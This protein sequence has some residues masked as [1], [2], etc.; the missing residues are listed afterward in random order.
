MARTLGRGS[1]YSE[2]NVHRR[3]VPLMFSLLL[4]SEGAMGQA[5]SIDL[6]ND[7]TICQGQTVTLTAPAGYPNYLWSTGASSQSIVVG[8]AGTFWGEA[9]YTSAQ[10]FPNSDFSAGATGF[11]TQ[12]NHSTVLV[13]EGNYWVGTNA[14]TYHPNFFGTGTGNFMMV[15]SGWPSAL[16]NVYCQDVVVCPQQTY[17]LRY[18]ARTLTNDIPAR[19]QWWVNGSPVGPEV[20]MPAFNAGWQTITQT[21]TSGV[22]VTN[23]NACLRVMSGDGIGNDFGIDDVTMQGTMRL[24][25]EVIVNVTPL[26]VF[27]LGPNATL[28]AGQNLVLDAAVPGGSYVWQDG[29]TDPGYVV[30]GPGTYSVT[31]T[32]NGCPATDAITVNYNALPVVNLGPDRTL[33]VGETTVLNATL[34]GATYVWQDGSTNGTYTVTGPGTYSVQVT[35]NNCPATDAVDIVYTPLPTVDLGADVDVCSGDVVLLDAT[36]TNGSY[37]WQDGSTGATFSPTT[38]GTYDVTV[39]VD[40][41]DATDAVNVNFRPLPLADLGPDQ[42]VCPGTV[43]TLD[44]TTAGASY[45]WQDGSTAPTLAATSPGTYDVEVT[46]NGCSANDSFTLSHFVLQTV[47]LGPDITICQGQAAT[48]GALVAG[49]GYTWSTGDGTATIGVS[50]AGTYWV[51]VAL[52][53]C[54]VRDSVNVVVTPLPVIELGPDAMICPGTTVTLDATTAE[55]TYTW[56]TG[57]H[58]ATLDVAAGIYDVTVT[59][60]NCTSTDNITITEWPAATV[61]LGPDVTLCPGTQ[62]ILDAA[63]PGASHVWQDGSTNST[64]TVT[65]GGTYD[66]ELTD[67]NGCTAN[68]AIT[69]TYASP[70]PIDLGADTTLCQGEALTLDATTPGASYVWNTGATT[71]TITVSSGGNYSVIVTQGSCTVSDAIVVSISQLPSVSLGPDVLLCPT[72]TLILDATGPGFTYAWS[73]GAITPTITVTTGGTYTVTVTNTANCTANDAVVVTYATPGSIDLGPD[74]VRCQGETVVLDASLPGAT[75]VWSTGASTPTITVNSTGTFSVTV[76]QGT[77]SVTDAVD[78][79]VNPMPQ[80]DLGNDVTLCAGEDI[81]LD[82]TWP[83]ASYAWSSGASTPTITV[84]STGTFSVDVDL[85]GCIASDAIDVNVLSATSVDVGP[86]QVICEGEQVI[87]DATTPGSSYVWSNGATTP[88]ITVT[89]SGTYSVTVS[90]GLC[91]V[92]DAVDVTVNPMPQVDLGN[93]VTLCAGED[94]LLDATWPGAS[95]A[96]SSGASTPT[97]TVNS[98]GTFSVDVDLNGCIASDA[99]DVNV[100]SATSVD[101]GPDQVICEGEQVILD[102]TTPGSSYVWSTGATT[103]TITVTTSGIYSVTVS[104]GLCSVTDAVDVT[105]NPMPQVDLGNDVTLCAGEDILLDATWPGASYAWSSGASTPTITVN[106]TGTFSVDVD[107]NGCIASDAIDVSVLSATSVD[108]GPDQVICEGEQVILDA[109]TPGSSYVW[110]TGATTPTITVTSSGTYS[111]TVSTGLCS[112]TD[113]VDVTM[114]PMPQVDLGADQVFCA[115]ETTT[116]LDATWPGANYVWSTGATTPTIEVDINGPYNV[117]VEL[118][119]CVATDMLTVTFGS[120]NYSLGADTTLCPGQTLLLGSDLPAGTAVWNGT[121]GS[122]TITVEQAGTYRLSFTT[123]S[124]CE[125]RDTIEVNYVGIDQV[126]LGADQ[127]LCEGEVLQ[128]DATTAGATYVWDDGSTGAVR[129]VSYSGEY[130]VEVHVGQCT[131]TDA[132]NVVFNP[133]P[134][135]NLGAD[136]PLCPTTTTTFDATTVDASYLWQDGSTEPTYTASHAGTVSVTVSVSGCSSSDAVEVTQLEGPSLLLGSDTTICSGADLLLLVNEA[137]TSYAWDD[138]SDTEERVVATE[139]YYWV[140]ATRNTCTVRDSIYV[141]VFSTSDLDLGSDITICAGGSTTL[142]A[143]YPGALYQWNTG[144]TSPTISVN[145]AG[146]YN[147]TIAVSGCSAEDDIT[148][149]VFALQPPQ[150]GA[151]RT[152]CEGESTE[153]S[154]LPTNAHILWSTGA[155]NNSI[156]V[157][158]AGTYTVTLD[159]LG[160]TASDI[161]RVSTRPM[162]TRIDLGPDRE[163]C[164]G[165]MDLLQAPFIAGASYTWT[166]GSTGAMLSIDAPGTYGVHATGE[167]IDARATIIVSPADCGTYIFVPNTFTPNG[168]GDNDLFLPSIAGPLD[169]YQLDIFDRWGERIHTTDDRSAGWDGQYNG[170]A[171]Q[172]GV[173]VWTLHYRVLGP[174]GVK[175]ERLVGHVTLLR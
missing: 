117:E 17:T 75:Y 22:G 106:S 55:A 48:I 171:A 154:I 7:H 81:L 133:L 153:L 132:I 43:V 141:N 161:I 105:V 20:N 78:V 130:A 95:Y 35:R 40:D 18:R 102:A 23:V 70:A 6:G 87:L 33:C 173:Y 137:G 2:V 92:T 147:V 72:E 135:V 121:N 21:W 10:L 168:D 34:P 71:P 109:T 66:V 59:A 160:C 116:T 64:Y 99:I 163:L 45:V 115:G 62:L 42:T 156:V 74:A 120:F 31:V 26:P 142:D 157:E 113:A 19:L 91:S 111:V 170:V 54:T 50:T 175:N 14:A 84:N 112:V 94:I 169:R 16:W 143:T 3:I 65:T 85:N 73:T 46:V 145:S 49:A 172:D 162:T 110:S 101:L 139:G 8:S 83:G 148:V 76:T 134:A 146:T 58:T 164:N 96:W 27:D 152:I 98:T 77:C 67:V 149:N 118:N 25:D 125:V 136:V 56:N 37:V 36:T 150:L 11:N 103:P 166:T 32:A 57:E 159:S 5:C 123:S 122:S 80:V 39:T 13:A 38:N 165:A 167:C 9:I 4:A 97:I 12:F 41:C 29:S 47:D 24:R 126:S 158:E 144:A 119:G 60:N 155:T 44:A 90:T 52:N 129:V 128:L 1:P 104:T 63:R 69:V 30:S 151:D 114:N 131:L 53:G 86:D 79:T 88:T 15:N 68:D 100:L 124:G 82:A 61:D 140:D 51:D 108:L 93:D 127:A 138:G 107:L 28:C 89:T 174:E